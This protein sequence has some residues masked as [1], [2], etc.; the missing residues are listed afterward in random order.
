MS[1]G[2][3]RFDGR[4]QSRQCFFHRVD[5]GDLRSQVHAEAHQLHMGQ[6]ANHVGDSCNV[7]DGNAKLRTLLSG[8]DVLVRCV[9]RH[10]GIH[11]NGDTRNNAPLLRD[12][13]E[14]VQLRF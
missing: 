6:L 11:T 4:Q 13:I 5:G 2:S 12:R 9:N 3:H 7:I 10:F 8:T 1:L 14:C